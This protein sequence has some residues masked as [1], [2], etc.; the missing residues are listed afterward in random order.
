[1]SN[2]DTFITLYILLFTD[3]WCADS[4]RPADETFQRYPTC[5]WTPFSI[6]DENIMYRAQATHAKQIPRILL[7]ASD[8]NEE[9]NPK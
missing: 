6:G 7:Q 9:E 5:S 3:D 4:V 8:G 1:M 2:L